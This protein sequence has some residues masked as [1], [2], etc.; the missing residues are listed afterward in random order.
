MVSDKWSTVGP[1]GRSRPARVTTKKFKSHDAATKQPCNWGF[2]SRGSRPPQS[3]ECSFHVLTYTP[4]TRQIVAASECLRF[5]SHRDYLHF[6]CARGGP[7]TVVVQTCTIQGTTWTSSRNGPSSVGA[8]R[9]PS[10]L[11]APLAVERNG[12]SESLNRGVELTSSALK[13]KACCPKSRFV[14]L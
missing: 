12:R 9:G 7:D 11:G 3:A 8:N 10:H 5:F 4:P 2:A 14:K 6:E 13:F 1:K